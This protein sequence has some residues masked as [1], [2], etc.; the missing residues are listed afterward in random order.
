MKDKRS[1]QNELTKRVSTEISFRLLATSKHQ[2]QEWLMEKLEEFAN[3]FNEDDAY[4]YT[5]AL[6]NN[7]EDKD[8]DIDGVAIVGED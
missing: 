7:S 5:Q 2:D 1:R 8:E 4:T 3:K 6:H